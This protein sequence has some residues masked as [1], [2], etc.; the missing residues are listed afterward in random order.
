MSRYQSLIICTSPRSGSTFLC[1]LLQATGKAGLPD[2]HFHVPSV[3]AWLEDHGLS[4]TDF[5]TDHDRLVAA[6]DAARVSGT[7]DTGMFGLR[8]QQ[9]SVAFFLQKLAE[10]YPGLPTD[11]ARLETAFGK[12]LY[13]HLTRP[14]KV[15][16]A[17]SRLRAEQSGLWHK[18]PDGTE[19][20]RLSPPQEP[21]YDGRALARHVDDM[22]SDDIAWQAW[23]AQEG[24]VPHRISYDELSRAPL[25]VLAGVLEALGLDRS[26]TDGIA[27]PTAKLA[28]EVSRSWADRFRAEIGA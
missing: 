15:D 21:H 20:E 1:R 8:L 9:H 6:F 11:T 17:V 24:V 14:D 16:Q 12:I 5:A 3:A 25:V 27:L 19:L 28:D 18:A 13:I 23:F 7:G 26:L 22:I 4:A 10:L 2:S